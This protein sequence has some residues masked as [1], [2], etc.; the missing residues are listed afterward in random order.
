MVNYRRSKLRRHI[1]FTVNLRDRNNGYHQHG[2]VSAGYNNVHLKSL[3]LWCCRII[4][5]SFSLKTIIFPAL[6]AKKADRAL[7]KKKK[8]EINFAKQEH[9]ILD[10]YLKHVDLQKSGEI[11]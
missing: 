6:E 9:Q 1:F 2:T 8:G 7:M 10:V 3:R 5:E 11:C 4:C